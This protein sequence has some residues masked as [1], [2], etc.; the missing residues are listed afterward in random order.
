MAGPG[1]KNGSKRKP[2]QPNGG[3]GTQAQIGLNEIQEQSFVGEL[4]HVVSAVVRLENRKEKF[5]SLFPLD[6]LSTPNIIHSLQN[7]LAYSGT[8]N[9][10]MYTEVLSWQI[11]NQP[12]AMQSFVCKIVM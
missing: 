9:C 8:G 6:T 3:Q 5:L 10:I 11:L 2:K 12:L 1:L 4:L 7:W